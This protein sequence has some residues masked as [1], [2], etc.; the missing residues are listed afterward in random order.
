M[1]KIQNCNHHEH[2]TDNQSVLRYEILNLFHL[3]NFLIGL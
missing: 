3:F 2:Q 1:K